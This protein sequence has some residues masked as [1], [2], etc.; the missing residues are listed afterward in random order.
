MFSRKVCEKCSLLFEVCDA[1]KLCDC[2]EETKLCK[3][4]LSLERNDKENRQS[5][6]EHKDR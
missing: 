2:I 1:K 4:C 6:H 3:Y 5:L